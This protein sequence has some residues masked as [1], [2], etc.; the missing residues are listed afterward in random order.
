MTADMII[1][2]GEVITCDDNQSN[3]SA[4]ALPIK[5]GHILSVGENG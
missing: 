5:D 3:A 1:L 4:N 2:N